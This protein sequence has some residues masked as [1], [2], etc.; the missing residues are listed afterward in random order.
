MAGNKKIT[1]RVQAEQKVDTLARVLQITALIIAA[2]LLVTDAL[3]DKFSLPVWAVPL[4][5]GIAA[6]LSPEQIAKIITDVVK[7][8]VTGKRK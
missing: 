7:A 5:L 2:V 6:G 3:I 8:F 4:I 1:A